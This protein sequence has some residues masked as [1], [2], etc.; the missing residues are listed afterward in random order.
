M[1]WTK[2]K[3][4]FKKDCLLLTA[5]N[6]NGEWWYKMFEIK[7]V[8]FD[9]SWYWGIFCDDGEEWGDLPDLR[10]QLYC[11]LPLLK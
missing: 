4:V 3:P 9:E 1:K 6:I 8:F 10:S 5:S 7:K 2:D 11:V